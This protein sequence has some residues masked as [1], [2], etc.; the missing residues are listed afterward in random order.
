MKKPIISLIAILITGNIC[1]AQYKNWN[2]DNTG[3]K[4]AVYL[5]LGYDYSLSLDAG[6]NRSLKLFNKTLLLGLDISLPMG[7]N[8]FDDHKI[9]IGGEMELLHKN[10]FYISAK[11][12][13]VIRRY[14]SDNVRIENFGSDMGVTAGYF[15]S[16]WY[17]AAEYG[18]DK[19]ISSHLVHTEEFKEIYPQVVD[20]W[21]VPAGGEFYYGLYTG[22]SINNFIDISLKLGATN[23]QG[24]DGNALLP[25]YAQ[26]GLTELF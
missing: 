4:N 18:F 24:Q 26:V 17:L 21:Y 2:S 19:A 10:D 11:L 9:K 1:F 25:Y 20:G 8:L 22:F 13:G 15:R 16:N 23:A 14:E 7:D 12:K 3:N 5:N 6:Y